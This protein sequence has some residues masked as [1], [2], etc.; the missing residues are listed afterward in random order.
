MLTLALGHARSNI[1]DMSFRT[2][3]AW[4]KYISSNVQDISRNV[5][6]ILG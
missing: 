2:H 6:D 4:T 1:F 5:H 3:L